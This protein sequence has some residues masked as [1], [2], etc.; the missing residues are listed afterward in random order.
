MSWWPLIWQSAW[1]RRQV[2]W[3]TV[4]SVALSAALLLGL[5]RLRADVRQSFA[6]AISGTDLIAGPRTGSVELLLY[7]VFHIGQPRANLP[8][9]AVEQL[10]ANPDVAWVIPIALGDSFRGF[11]V[12][13]T[14]DSFFTHF[15][16]G[17]QQAL[18]WQSGQ[19][20]AG[21]SE[22]VL[23]AEVARRLNL[24]VGD[25]VILAHGDGAMAE[26]DHSDHPMTVVGVLAP[27]GTPVDRALH[28]SLQAMAS[29]H[30]HGSLGPVD[31]QSAADMR[32]QLQALMRAPEQPTAEPER[33][34]DHDHDHDHDHNH[35]HDHDHGRDARPSSHTQAAPGQAVTAALVGLHQRT[36]VFAVQQR[37]QQQ[38]DGRW[39]A[40]LPGVALDELWGV[41]DLAERALQVVCV[42]VAGVSLIGLSA[43]IL[44]GLQA[45]RRELAVLRAVGASPRQIAGLMALEGGFITALGVALGTALGW[46]ALWALSP[47]LQRQHG[48]T[49]QALI[50]PAQ[51]QWLALVWAAGWAVSLLPAWQAYRWSVQD[52]LNPGA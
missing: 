28:V 14:D 5:E 46:L 23:G 42:L 49:V 2:L 40:V 29:L 13:A 26:H 37:F 36:R 33:A 30:A 24:Q 38:G 8:W 39:M 41:I 7:A 32:Q 17:E 50:E 21:D 1:H 12:V 16:H 43:T 3:L 45:R 22:V 15:R 18:H 4:M 6:Q 10:R 52:G 51:W 31:G 20:F 19:A 11:P 34:H 44:A 25:A 48:L 9:A 35:D 47:W 27:T